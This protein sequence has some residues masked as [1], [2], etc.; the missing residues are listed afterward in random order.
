MSRLFLFAD[1]AGCFNFSRNKSASRYF[2]VCTISCES[3]SELGTKLLDLRRELIWRREPVREYFHASEDRQTIRDRVFEL[4]EAQPFQVQATIMEKSKALPKVRPTKE[5][6]YHYG[7]YYHLQYAA[8][9]IVRHAQHIL[10]TAASVGTHKGQAHF[11]MAVNDVAQ[12]V[13]KGGRQFRTNFC[14]SI[15]DPCLQAA[16]YCTWAIQRKWEFGDQR[17]YALIQ[18]KIVHEADMW[19]HGTT[20]HY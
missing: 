16:D 10:I 4:L 20:H 1:E 5:R 15:A 12:Q 3:C 19:S 13:I 11:S 17:S 2:I 6:F 18:S 8:P 14:R 7:W 9:K